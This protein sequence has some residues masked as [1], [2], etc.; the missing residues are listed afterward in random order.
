MSRCTSCGTALQQ[1]DRFCSECGRPVRSADLGLSP[2]GACRVCGS[3]VGDE[4]R[5]CIKCGAAVGI[6]EKKRGETQP[7]DVSTTIAAADSN[8]PLNKPDW[9]QHAVTQRPKRRLRVSPPVAIVLLGCA[10]ALGVH[11]A[12]SRRTT[13]LAV[14]SSKCGPSARVDNNA[15]RLSIKRAFAV[16]YGNYDPNLDGAFW[17]PRV[18]PPAFARWNGRQLFIRPLISRSFRHLDKSRQVVVTN[19]LDVQ[20]GEVVKQGTGCRECGSLIGAAIFEQQK[21]GWQLI[22]RHDFLA[23][24]GSWGGPPA[25]ALAIDPAGTI[26]LRIRSRSAAGAQRK[27]D[28]SIKLVERGV[29]ARSPSTHGTPDDHDQ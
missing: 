13:D 12:L 10:L 19:S 25:V 9:A 4:I 20:N 27:P 3:A 29:G 11:L 14:S 26:D 17:T 15:E 28:Y 24:D 22:S 16:L 21:N 8:A 18:A 2:S 1:D 5:F 6:S 23:A 7:R